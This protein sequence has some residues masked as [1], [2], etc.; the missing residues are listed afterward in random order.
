MNANRTIITTRLGPTLW[1]Y[2]LSFP[3]F[4]QDINSSWKTM[5]SKFP[6]QSRMLLWEHFWFEIISIGFRNRQN[7]NT[8]PYTKLSNILQC[9]G[10]MFGNKVRYTIA[11]GF[12]LYPYE[13]LIFDETIPQRFF[14][15]IGVKLF[16]SKFLWFFFIFHVV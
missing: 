13:A 8:K 14:H 9:R 1:F 11:M 5:M 3:Q 10:I 7:K 16:M 15:Y 12:F 6:S 4:P 2:L